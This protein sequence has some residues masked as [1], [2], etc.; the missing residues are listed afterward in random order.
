MSSVT[1]QDPS[2][3][4]PLPAASLYNRPPRRESTLGSGP[5]LSHL[6]SAPTPGHP[7]MGP[8]QRVTPPR[9]MAGVGPQVR[10]RPR[11]LQGLPPLACTQGPF[12]LTELRKWHA[13]PTQ[14][15]RW[16]R[17]AH[18]EH[19]RPLRDPQRVPPGATIQLRGAGS[20]QQH[21]ISF[22]PL[23][24]GETEPKGQ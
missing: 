1:R 5:D 23:L 18:N 10:G 13:A 3:K 12:P 4:C 21:R 16:P 8:M 7:N 17:P 11:G 24:V 2:S 15:P 9:G 14:L 6:P 19:V 22:I 20:A